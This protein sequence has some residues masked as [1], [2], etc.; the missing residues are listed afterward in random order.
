MNALNFRRAGLVTAS[1]VLAVSLAACAAP[2]QH[3][4]DNSRQ[5]SAYPAPARG[6]EYGRVAN[7]YTLQGQRSGQTTGAG[8]VLG[9]V[10]GGV[11]GHQVGKGSG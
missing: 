4:P 11:L 10:V 6:T 9:A 3:Y 2:R 7:V 8:A 5:Q 1:A